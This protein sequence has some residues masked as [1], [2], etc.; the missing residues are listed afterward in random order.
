[1]IATTPEIE[2]YL[3]QFEQLAERREGAEPAWLASFRKNAIER[4]AE[5]GFPTT[6]HEEWKYTSV[7]PIEETRF[8]PASRATGLTPAD[9]E[10]RFGPASVRLVFMNGHYAP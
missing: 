3:A 4:F 5:F 7:R 6:R 10:S 2:G 8:R 1:M 9:V